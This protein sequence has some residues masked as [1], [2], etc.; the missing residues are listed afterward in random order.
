MIVKINSKKFTIHSDKTNIKD[1]FSLIFFIN[2]RS[3]IIKYTPIFFYNI[4]LNFYDYKI[5]NYVNIIN[6]EDKNINNKNKINNSFYNYFK[7]Y[8][9]KIDINILKYEIDTKSFFIQDKV[10]RCN[11]S[12][13]NIFLG[14]KRLLLILKNVNVFIDSEE[15]QKIIS[16]YSDFLI[17]PIYL[18]LLNIPYDSKNLNEILFEYCDFII[19]S[20]CLL[21]EIHNYKYKENCIFIFKHKFVEN[22]LK[23]FE[24]GGENIKFI[25][26]S[27]CLNI[28]FKRLKNHDTKIK[29]LNLY[30]ILIKKISEQQY[31]NL[32]AIGKII[33]DISDGNKIHDFIKSLERSSN[34]EIKHIQSILCLQSRS[35]TQIINL[36]NLSIQQIGSKLINKFIN[37]IYLIRFHGT[38]RR[39]TSINLYINNF[40]NQ[41][42]LKSE[43]NKH[44]DF[45][46]KI[47]TQLQLISKNTKEVL[48]ENK[49][50]DFNDSKEFQKLCKKCNDYQREIVIN[51]KYQNYGLFLEMGLGKTFIAIVE[52]SKYYDIVDKYILILPTQ[53]QDYWLQEINKHDAS[54]LLDKIVFIKYSILSRMNIFEIITIYNQHEH[55]N[56]MIFLEESTYV[57]STTSIRSENIQFLLLLFK[58]RQNKLII[59]RL[60]T[61]T[62]YSNS[63]QQI[64]GQMVLLNP[65]VTPSFRTFN[66]MCK[67][68]VLF[69]HNNNNEISL[70]EIINLVASKYEAYIQKDY[71]SKAHEVIYV[72]RHFFHSYLVCIDKSI[73][74]F[75]IKVNTKIL[76]I[77]DKDHITCLNNISTQYNNMLK[78]EISNVLEN[79]YK[80]SK[81]ELKH[82]WIE[83]N[84]E[85]IK[86]RY[87]FPLY[88]FAS[89]GITDSFDTNLKKQLTKEKQDITMYHVSAK[90]RI[91]QVILQMLNK[92]DKFIY[93]SACR[94]ALNKISEVFNEM[95]I[96][97][98]MITGDTKMSDRQK[99]IDNY[100]NNVFNILLSSVICLAYG[101][102][103]YAT[104]VIVINEPIIQ[105]EIYQQLK[106]RIMRIDTK[107]SSINIYI[108]CTGEIHHKMYTSLLNNKQ[109]IDVFT[110]IAKEIMESP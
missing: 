70:Y 71:V 96:K 86:Y 3:N 60:L 9:V 88:F 64:R 14:Y 8:N 5:I 11:L 28:G 109:A 81:N 89:G 19:V 18:N 52:M 62:P 45:F 31:G 17:F 34:L 105:M 25:F 55:Q 15:H 82:Y 56:V 33:K 63:L 35:L 73:I 67:K 41:L 66:D 16:W 87:F 4:P 36:S 65:F 61:G 75:K 38:I 10:N 50:I 69:N 23:Y 51:L 12:Y 78:E 7:K 107:F 39:V 110:N 37:Y 46:K 48:L 72:L 42:K 47:F 27:Y 76:K 98:Q 53:L 106:N 6:I 74:G 102:S 85:Y 21:C 93:V 44:I 32:S 1:I 43:F 90:N 49:K 101:F 104:N 13:V 99:I 20:F 94:D 2:R 22:I 79:K 26:A 91:K 30:N 95:K 84:I 24:S 100:N 29:I 54:F 97:Y 103:I 57:K 40:L 80:E 68:C 58:I 59:L 92:H 108:A 83:K 77:Y